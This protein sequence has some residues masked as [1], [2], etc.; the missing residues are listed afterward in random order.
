MIASYLVLVHLG[1]IAIQMEPWKCICCSCL[2]SIPSV[3]PLRYFK[4]HLLIKLSS[5]KGGGKVSTKLLNLNIPYTHLALSFSSGGR[6]NQSNFMVNKNH[7]MLLIF[8]Q[9]C[10]NWDLGISL[11]EE[12]MTVYILC[13]FWMGVT[14][15]AFGSVADGRVG[16]ED[17]KKEVY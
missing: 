3:L 17:S 5:E 6:S 16:M 13:I 15:E 14:L 12:E 4:P 11:T 10:C 1:D 2:A 9:W 8:K 7:S